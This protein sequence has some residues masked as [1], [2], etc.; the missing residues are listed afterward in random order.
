MS[1]GRYPFSAGEAVAATPLPAGACDC[2]LHVYDARVPATPGATLFPPDATVDDYLQVQARM[3]TARAVLVTPSTYGADNTLL[4]AGLAQ[5]A[6]RGVEARGVAVLTGEEDE[7]SLRGLHAQG[8][9]GVRINLSLGATN[10]AGSIPRIARRIAPLGWHLQL[11]M[12]AAQLTALAPVL[13]GLPVDLVFDHFGRIPPGGQGREPAHALLLELLGAG[14]AWVKVSGGYL[15]S[16][17]GSVE[18]P[19]LDDLARSFIDAAP[20]RVVWGSDWP[21]ATASAGR[22]PMP[23]DARQVDRLAQWAGDARRLH[24]ILVANPERLYGFAPHPFT[25]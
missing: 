6:Q 21:H 5:L 9:R 8:V 4:L 25:D 10:D 17:Q 12:P 3:G 22:Q 20:G 13:R 18:D 1:Q 14:R 16:P 24:Q 23:D 11:L 15:V 7:A 19:G 2:H